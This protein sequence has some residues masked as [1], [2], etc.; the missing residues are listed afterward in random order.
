M[1][2][3][4]AEFARY[5]VA[6]RRGLVGLSVG[7]AIALLAACGSDGPTGPAPANIAG[8]WEFVSPAIF[9]GNG[10]WCNYIRT[11]LSIVQ[12]GSHFSGTYSIPTPECSWADGVTLGPRITGN[13]VN[14]TVSDTAFTFAFDGVDIDSA[15]ASYVSVGVLSGDSLAGTTTMRAPLVPGYTETLTGAWS[16]QRVSDTPAGAQATGLPSF[17][18]R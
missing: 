12:S 11:T 18:R 2:S 1:A 6:M 3:G 16:A 17:R 9:S 14:G 15:A 7:A 10:Y 13:V 8:T 4:S 5:F